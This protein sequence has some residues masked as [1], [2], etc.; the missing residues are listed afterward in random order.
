MSLGLEN[1]T[2]QD[3]AESQDSEAR[4]SVG[5]N[6]GYTLGYRQRVEEINR[7]DSYGYCTDED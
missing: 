7:W 4:T 2:D 6:P 5:A 3:R 1:L